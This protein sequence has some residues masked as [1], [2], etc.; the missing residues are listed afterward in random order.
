M[1]IPW[2]YQRCI[3]CLDEGPLTKAH[4]I[5]AAIGGRLFSSLECHACNARLGHA[6]E[7]RLKSDPCVRFGIE[8]LGNQV[9]PRLR[10]RIRARE[11]LVA[12]I[13]DVTGRAYGTDDERYRLYDTP[14]SDG[15]VVKDPSAP[16]TTS[17]GHL[18]AAARPTPRSRLRSSAWT[19]HP[20]GISCMSLRASPSARDP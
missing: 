10:R 5:P 16:A 7:A 9:P 6:I 8:A 2:P 19:M 15:S 18:P 17:L 4:L 11:P 14:Q 13:G 12:T 3:S 20:T 1:R